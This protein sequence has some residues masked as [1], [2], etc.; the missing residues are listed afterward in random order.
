MYVHIHFISPLSLIHSRLFIAVFEPVVPDPNADAS[1][2][3]ESFFR[4]EK[5]RY[6]CCSDCETHTH[7]NTEASSPG[8]ESST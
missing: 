4:T 8:G 1:S 5:S 2:P 7:T 6:R 3:S